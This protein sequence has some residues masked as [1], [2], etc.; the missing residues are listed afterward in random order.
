LVDRG[1]KLV[2]RLSR[3]LADA[4]EKPIAEIHIGREFVTQERAQFVG[5]GAVEFGVSSC[6]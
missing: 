5:V 2:D 1:T 6:S 3:R 4:G